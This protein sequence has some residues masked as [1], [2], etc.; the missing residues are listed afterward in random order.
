MRELSVSEFG[1][2]SGGNTAPRP[3]G[4]QS[5][6]SRAGGFQV[7][8]DV[9]QALCQAALPRHAQ[10]CNAALTAGN[11]AAQDRLDQQIQSALDAVGRQIDRVGVSFCRAAES[12][13]NYLRRGS[14]LPPVSY[15][16]GG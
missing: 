14:G 8:Y 3:S 6:G 9:N 1:F 2:V 7:A 12:T 5:T 15:G 11:E 13:E 16:C 10:M 4:G